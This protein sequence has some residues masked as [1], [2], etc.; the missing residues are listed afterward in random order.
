MQPDTLSTPKIWLTFLFKDEEAMA[1]KK[2]KQTQPH[3]R[4]TDNVLSS[5]IVILTS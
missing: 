2:G 3:L 1:M 5:F 4:G